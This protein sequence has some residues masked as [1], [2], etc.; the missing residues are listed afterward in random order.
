MK[1]IMSEKL[2]K[3][4]NDPKKAQELQRLLGTSSKINKTDNLQSNKPRFEE[5]HAKK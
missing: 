1:A 2:R 4:L 5:A 3:I